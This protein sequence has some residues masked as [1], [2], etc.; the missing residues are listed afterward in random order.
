MRANDEMRKAAIALRL[1]GLST[2]QIAGKLDIRL[3]STLQGWLVGTPPPEWTKRP[4]AKDAERER[5]REMRRDGSS[6]GEI[7]TAL[8]VAK[9]SVSLWVRDLPNQEKLLFSDDPRRAGAERYFANRRRAVFIERQNEKLGW[10]NEIGE[11]TDRELLIAGAVAYWAEGGKSKPHRPSESMTFI[12]SDPNMIRLFLAWLELLGVEPD[13]LR[14][15]VSIHESADTRAAELFWADVV[16]ASP[17][18]FSRVTLK[19]HNPT[20][21]RHNTGQSYHGC[22]VIRV[23]KSASLYRRME[24]AWWAVAARARDVDSR[25]MRRPVA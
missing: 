5:A 14:F 8:G 11:L 1:Q 15:R 17:T 9:S 4:K 3:N 2:R 10:A 18:E 6:Y 16:G 19:R 23:L 20:T 22:L 21:V 12:N 24:G 13:R 7:A 25:H